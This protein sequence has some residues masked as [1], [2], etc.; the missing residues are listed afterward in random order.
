MAVL[1][2]PTVG[3]FS[4]SRNNCSFWFKHRVLLKYFIKKHAPFVMVIAFLDIANSTFNV[5]FCTNDCPIKILKLE[6]RVE[7]RNKEVDAAVFSVLSPGE[8]HGVQPL[9]LIPVISVHYYNSTVR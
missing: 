3:L 1:R 8:E 7:S 4:N 5:H 6:I 9:V 2:P